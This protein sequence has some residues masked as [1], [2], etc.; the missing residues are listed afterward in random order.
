MVG[1]PFAKPSPTPSEKTVEI[2]TIQGEVKYPWGVV[3]LATVRAGDKKA[4]TDRTGKFEIRALDAG[5]YTISVEPPFPG[6]EAQSQIVAVAAGQT[7]QVY[8]FLDFAKTTVHGYVYGKDG[9]PIP[10]AILSDVMC[11]KDLKSTV[12]DGTGYFKFDGASP[13]NLF[14]RVNA[15]GYMGETLDFASKKGEK[16]KLEFHLTPASCKISGIVSDEQGGPLGGEVILSSESMVILQKV[17]SNAESGYYE[18]SVVP[19][20]YNI[21]ANA[22]GYSSEGWRGPVSTDSKVNLKLTAIPASS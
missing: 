13:G 11:G 15:T 5:S 8:F 18:F 12:T 2:G 10:G 22:A 9:K 6:Y 17:P 19:G 21:L 20:T 3:A 16:T 7:K 4:V 1:N 14:V